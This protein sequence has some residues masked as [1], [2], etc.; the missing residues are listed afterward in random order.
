M[1]IFI[2]CFWCGHRLHEALKI[3]PVLVDNEE[4]FDLSIN[5]PAITDHGCFEKY[6]K[7]LRIAIEA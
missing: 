4:L 5:G 7:E 2:I 3:N 6:H 1:R